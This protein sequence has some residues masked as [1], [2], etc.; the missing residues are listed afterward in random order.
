[1][2][3]FRSLA[4][5]IICL[6]PASLPAQFLTRPVNLAYLS[7]RAGVIV[8]GRVSSVRYEPMPGY[9]HLSTV[10]VTLEV[11]QML[12]GP[13][14][15]QYTFRQWLPGGRARATKYGAY[16]VG[17]ELVLFL[18]SPSEYG[19]SSPIGAEQGMF[20]VQRDAQ[21]R[22][23]IANGFGNAG[24]F[25]GVTNDADQEGLRLSARDR[26]TAAQPGPVPLDRFVGLVRTLMTMPRIE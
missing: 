4:L 17:S 22:K 21:G 20:H 13:Q 25:N 18:V 16:Q 8:Q 14:T 6:V 10:R 5:V 11:G 19:L 12:R 9:E 15:R 24:V 3:M 2:R 26:E 7:R 1:M 23:Y